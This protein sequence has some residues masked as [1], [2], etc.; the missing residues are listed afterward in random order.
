MHSQPF[1]TTT[2]IWQ[3]WLISG[4]IILSQFI[5]NNINNKDIYLSCL[6]CQP[7]IPVNKH[8][9]ILVRKYLLI[10]VSF[11]RVRIKTLG[12]CAACRPHHPRFMSPLMIKSAARTVT[13][14]LRHWFRMDARSFI[15]MTHRFNRSQFN[16]N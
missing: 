9:L 4:S 3:H 12:I 7:L 6:L 2:F 11:I 5:N 1:K 14:Q 10:P 8:P 15:G 13:F 16:Y